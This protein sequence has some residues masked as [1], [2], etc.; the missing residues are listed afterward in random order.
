MRVWGL[1]RSMH[2]NTA[3]C[4]DG[5]EPDLSSYVCISKSNDLMN[6]K[7]YIIK[8]ITYGMGF[9]LVYN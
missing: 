2:V 9:R 6:E 1:I 5:T 3:M 7:Q 8:G 4:N